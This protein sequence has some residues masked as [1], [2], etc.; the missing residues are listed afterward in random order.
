MIGRWTK[1]EAQALSEGRTLTGVQL[2]R[3]LSVAQRLLR[4]MP[5]HELRSIS[6]SALLKSITDQSL[7]AR[8]IQIRD[9]GDF[10]AAAGAAANLFLIAFEHIESAAAHRAYAQKAYPDRAQIRRR[11]F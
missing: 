5:A 2:D 7:G 8:H 6:T 4:S 3:S 1:I 10:D 9:H 11:H